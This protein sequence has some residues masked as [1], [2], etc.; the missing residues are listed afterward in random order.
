MLIL[1][2]RQTLLAF[3]QNH[4]RL[5][6]RSTH[7]S[8]RATKDPHPIAKHVISIRSLFSRAFHSSR[9]G[10]SSCDFGGPCA[11]SQCMQ[12]A[13]KPMCERCNVHPTVHQSYEDSCDRKGIRGYDS[14][15]LCEECWQKR[16]TARR[17]REVEKKQISAAHKARVSSM[18]GN[19]QRIRLTEQVPI[20]CAV[21]KFM[22]DVKPVHN[23]TP[24]G[25]ITARMRKRCENYARRSGSPPL[26]PAR[27]VGL[28]SEKS[29]LCE[30]LTASGESS[31]AKS[32][33]DYLESFRL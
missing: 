31:S 27:I 28:K 33:M 4:V 10:Y 23:Y 19:V 30:V 7:G 13:R 25:L 21:D 9:S 29:D 22:I 20:A 26:M 16:E 12:D 3:V 15:S 32:S 11:C 5:F 6:R 2:G 14:T 24:S 8:I 1:R 17:E 18:L